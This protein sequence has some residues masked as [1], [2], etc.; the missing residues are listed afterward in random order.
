MTRAVK[1]TG[2]KSQIPVDNANRFSKLPEIIG[3]APLH[4]GGRYEAF[5]NGRAVEFLGK[6][7]LRQTAGPPLFP[8]VHGIVNRGARDVCQ[9]GILFEIVRRIKNGARSETFAFANL[10]VMTGKFLNGE[11][12]NVRN[13]LLIELGV[14]NALFDYD[15]RQPF[16]FTFHDAISE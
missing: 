8:A 5:L 3:V 14:E 6:Q 11:P 4:F 10:Q 7:Q 9:I 12:C 1:L 13:L 15:S 2:K 16:M